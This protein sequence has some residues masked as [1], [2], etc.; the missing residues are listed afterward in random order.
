MSWI[1]GMDVSILLFIQEHIRMDV[2]NPFW[3]GI[4]ALGDAGLFWI[5]LGIILLI[6]RKTR[7]VG[8][9]VLLSLALGA[10]I[11][12]VTLKNLV[13]RIR[14]YDLVNTIVPLVAKPVDFSF[15]SGHT[16]ASFA[17]AEVYYRMLPKK[18]G[19]SAM[20]LAGMI[21]FSRMYVGVHYPTDVI[22]GILVGLASGA[23]VCY[24]MN[25][26]EEKREGENRNDIG[27]TKDTD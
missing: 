1:T 25:R 18:Y 22:G 14:P 19:I 2:M 27:N 10:L 6:P 15:P 7:K 12:N 24:G 26:I 17:S 16:C 23:I 20:I 3:K 21:A 5:I 4:T 13:A 8:W 11:T 9:M